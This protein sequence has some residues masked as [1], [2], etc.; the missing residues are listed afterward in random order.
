MRLKDRLMLRQ[1]MDY[2]RMKIRELAKAAGVSRATIGHL[3]SG[4]RNTCSPATARR[5]E[6]ALGAPPGLLFV[7]TSST[8]QREVA[9]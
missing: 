9:A 1:Y 2:K 7:V 4:K 8:V 6:E 3:H 5:V